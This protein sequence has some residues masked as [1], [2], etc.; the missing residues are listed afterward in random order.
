MKAIERKTAPVVLLVLDRG[1][2]LLRIASHATRSSGVGKREDRALEV[3]GVSGRE[4]KGFPHGM[5]DRNAT[6]ERLSGVSRGDP[7]VDGLRPST[8]CRLGAKKKT[9]VRPNP[10]SAKT[11]E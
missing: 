7:G 6:L 10:A 11:A 3:P 1:R 9:G 5:L 4:T 8:D 2:S